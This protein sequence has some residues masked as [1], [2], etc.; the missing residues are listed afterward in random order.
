MLSRVTHV[1]L[2]NERV[3]KGL[4]ELDRLDFAGF[5]RVMTA[6]GKSAL[7]LFE[8][9]A[10]APELTFLVDTLHAIPGVLGVRNMGGGFSAITLALVREDEAVRVARE[11][12]ARYA[13]RWQSR[14]V[15]IPFVASSGL[16]VTLEQA[17][18][19]SAQQ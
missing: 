3:R 12:E 19:R 1:V 15:T 18:A 16:S 10:G 7:E 2:E 5:G 6:S 13:E 11:I 9:D 8:L 14:L 17:D 4:I